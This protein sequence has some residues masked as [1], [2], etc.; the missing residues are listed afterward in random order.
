MCLTEVPRRFP[1][2][3]YKAFNVTDQIKWYF[4]ALQCIACRNIG[5]NMHTSFRIINTKDMTMALSL[6]V[7]L[8]SV[9]SPFLYVLYWSH[10]IL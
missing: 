3:L 4:I 10:L 9:N 1:S 8:H 6:N 7:C 2:S 5:H